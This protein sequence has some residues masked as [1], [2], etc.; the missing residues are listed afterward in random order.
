MSAADD[1]PVRAGN[2]D[3]HRRGHRFAG[4]IKPEALAGVDR[5]AAATTIHCR[6]TIAPSSSMPLS[7]SSCA[8]QPSSFSS[9][10]ASIA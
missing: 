9:L 4:S 7:K 1:L 6:D 5:A 10:V 2:H 3:P 8:R